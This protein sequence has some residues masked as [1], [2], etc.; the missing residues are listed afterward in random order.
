MGGENWSMLWKHV[1][2]TGKAEEFQEQE[3]EGKVEEVEGQGGGY[4]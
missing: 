3:G 2:E 1:M 4:S